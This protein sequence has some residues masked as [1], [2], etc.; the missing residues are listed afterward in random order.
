[1]RLEC[2]SAEDFYSAF[3]NLFAEL[4]RLKV[5]NVLQSQ[6]TSTDYKETTET[7]TITLGETIIDSSTS[8]TA[9]FDDGKSKWNV[10]KWT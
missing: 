8:Y 3:A 9:K 2:T 7:E 4:R 6:E 1:M 5:E 10:S